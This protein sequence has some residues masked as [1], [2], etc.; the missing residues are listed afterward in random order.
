M[1]LA[2]FIAGFLLFL[3]YFIH[4]SKREVFSQSRL[5]ILQS[6]YLKGAY[7]KVCCTLVLADLKRAVFASAAA[8]FCK[9]TELY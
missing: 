3:C 5:C 2:L 8:A 4:T 7:V 6:L 9:K 1:A